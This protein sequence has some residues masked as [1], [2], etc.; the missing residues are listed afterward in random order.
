VL[1]ACAPA[2]PPR[3]ISWPAATFFREKSVDFGG[4]QTADIADN[5]TK[6][7][8]VQP[9]WGGGERMGYIVSEIWVAHPDLWVQA[10]YNLGPV[11][12]ETVF[13]VDVDSTFYSPFWRAWLVTGEVGE[14]YQRVSDVNRLPMK[15]GP[16]VL[17]PIVPQG[18]TVGP[19]A[20]LRVADGG[21]TYGVAYVDGRKV[22]YLSFGAERQLV[23]PHLGGEADG[24]ARPAR[25]HVFS[26]PSADGGFLKDLPAVLPDDTWHRA[27]V[28]RV[29]TML[30]R[31]AVFVPAD[32]TTGLRERLKGLGVHVPDASVAIPP[33]EARKHRGHVALDGTCFES[34]AGLASCKWLDSEQKLEDG[35][36]P[37]RRIATDVT[38]TANPVPLP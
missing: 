5:T 36:P 19:P 6:Q 17:C 16:L 24:V 22:D 31:E 12:Q 8:L 23:E 4:W 29:D 38:L 2:A 33:E 7:L 1:A 30:E 26:R 9:A 15:K 14:K 13:T 28:K 37:F 10:V 21:I 11:Q 3:A 18:V 35:V 34:A 25:L 27:Y 20:D 32:D